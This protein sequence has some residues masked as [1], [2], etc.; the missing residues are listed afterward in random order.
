[1]LGTLRRCSVAEQVS[2]YAVHGPDAQKLR[3]ILEHAISLAA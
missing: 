2:H 1:M 3:D